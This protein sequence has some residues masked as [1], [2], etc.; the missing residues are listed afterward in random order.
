MEKKR[1]RIGIVGFGNVGKAA[2]RLIE[3][4][5]KTFE[6]Q[7]LDLSLTCVLNRQGGVFNPEGLDCAALAKH[8]EASQRLEEF[9]GFHT[10]LTLPFILDKKSI[11][12]LAEF[13][14]TNKETGEPALTTLRQCLKNGIHVT[15]GNKGPILV[16]WK[17]LYTLASQKGLLLGI[18]CT[19]GGAL[20]TLINGLDAMS[21]SEISS[22]EGIL[23]GTTNFI[24]DQMDDGTVSYPEAL[25]EAQNASI[26]ETDPTMDVEGWDTAIKLLIMTQ[27]VMQCELRLSD[28]PVKGITDITKEDMLKAKKMNAKMKLIGRAWRENGEIRAEVKPRMV[29]VTHPLY[30][31][32]DKNKGVLFVSDTMG[33][34][35]ISGGASGPIP[36]AAAALRDVINARKTGLLK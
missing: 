11:D 27:V 31:V 10:G 20:P 14:P 17:E 1:F 34:L 18:G 23:N 7:G 32:S 16:A 4:K 35:F 12:I 6:S 28:L 30:R 26:A 22:I 29:D 19:T 24:L 15:T 9:P 3:M 36:A 13:T 2:V 33:E 8:V 21:G 25:K 5:R